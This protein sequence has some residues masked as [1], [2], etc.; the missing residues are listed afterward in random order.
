MKEIITIIGARP[1]FIKTALLSRQLRKNFQEIVIH[2]GQHYDL[3]MSDIFYKDL[4]LPEVDY[5]LGVGSGTQGKQTGMMLEKIEEILL[6]EKPDL[7]L[8]FGDTNSTVAGALAAT[9]LNIPVAHVESGMRSFNRRM[10]EEINR[11][12]ADHISDLLFCST[13]SAVDL[14]KE[15]GI[16]KNVYMVGDVTFDLQKN[17]LSEGKASNILAELDLNP[18]EYILTTV[19]RQENTDKKENLVSILQAFK[20]IGTT[21]VWPIHP[22]TKKCINEYGLTEMVNTIANLRIVDPISYTETIELEK[23]A[24]LILTDSGGIQKEAYVAEVPCVTMRNETEWTETVESGWNQLAGTD[25]KKIV[26]LVHNFPEPHSHP[27]FF[28]DGNAYKKI[29][30]IVTDFLN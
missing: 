23:N 5:N 20:E 13:E 15:E 14:L 27:N 26:D 19:H 2:T 12:V 16:T 7:V 22:R 25:T 8:I 1:Q 18:K 29:T 24:K 21:I 28:G 4:N 9:K 10:P 17:T 3:K 30:Q 6:E 11:V